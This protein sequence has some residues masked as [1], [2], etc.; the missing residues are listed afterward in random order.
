[1]VDV[2]S[3]MTADET[4]GSNEGGVTVDRMPLGM[5]SN[6]IETSPVNPPERVSERLTEVVAS[7][8]TL[9]VPG[10]KPISIAGTGATT[11]SPLHAATIT[12]ATSAPI[13]L[14]KLPYLAGRARRTG[15]E[16]TVDPSPSVADT[17]H[18]SVRCVFASES[19]RTNAVSRIVEST[20]AA[21]ASSIT[22]SR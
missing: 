2:R 22:S 8:L 3:V 5:L 9:S 7:W 11:S 21:P 20:S 4:A 19:V 17:V 15:R 16:E 12:A 18:E 14:F 13:N 1:M 10:D 6:T